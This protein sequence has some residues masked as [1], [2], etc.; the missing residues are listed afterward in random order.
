M[1]CGLSWD[2]NQRPSLV[3]KTNVPQGVG[4]VNGSNEVKGPPEGGVGVKAEPPEEN[5]PALKKQMAQLQEIL[6]E[7]H[8]V[9]IEH[10]KKLD[11]AEKAR[12]KD[13]PVETQLQYKL[14]HI[15]KLEYQLS[16]VDENLD[17]LA[18]KSAKLQE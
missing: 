11:A 12:R 1:Q 14:Q 18:D 2:W 5:I 9:T 16:K 3:P 13:V 10:R 15:K 7:D 8:A 6:G 4:G 17:L